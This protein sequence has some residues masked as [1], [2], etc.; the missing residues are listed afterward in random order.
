MRICVDPGHNYSGYDTGASGNGLREQDVTFEIA[1][2]LKKLLVGAGVE[3]TMTRGRLTDNVGIN[4]SDSINE[5]AR[6]ANTTKCDYFVS[7]HCNA[8]GGT[9]TETLIYGRGGKA[10]GLAKS[11]NDAIVNKLSLKDRGVKVRTDLG[12]LRLT[13][14][15]AILVETAF[16]DHKNDSQ[17][18]K[19]K[20]N[21]FAQAIFDGICGFLNI[22]EADFSVILKKVQQKAGLADE[23]MDYLL[24]YD[25]GKELVT[26]LYNAMQ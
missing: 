13:D 21:E 4:A 1:D 7:V 9:G 17:L 25:Y 6:I 18:L 22:G 10:E 8:G 5:R 24:G 12:V 19:N 20:Q 15:P 26:K 14:M 3:V 23:T 2:R 11:V 16:I